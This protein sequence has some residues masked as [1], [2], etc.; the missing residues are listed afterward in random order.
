MISIK[1]NILSLSLSRQMAKTSGALSSSF[2][3]LSSGSRLNRASDDPG[4][5]AVAVNLK[6]SRVVKTRAALNVSDGVSALEI[7]SGTLSSVSTLLT[8]MSEL[9]G[10]GSNGSYSSTQR[11]A[12][13]KE[14]TQLGLELHRISQSTTF[15]GQRLL[16][17]QKSA[18]A[19]S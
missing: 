2:E 14:F 10:Q 15:N 9:A 12:L 6:T 18:R 11:A 4:G 1:S 8:R 5:L 17:G 7:A 16:D 19:A 13:D 3:K